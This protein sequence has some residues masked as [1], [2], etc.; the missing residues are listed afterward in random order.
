MWVDFH[1]AL[2]MYYILTDNLT[3]CDIPAV[4]FAP[5]QVLTTPHSLRGAGGGRI[6]LVGGPPPAA[7]LH[8]GQV[9]ACDSTELGC[10]G[11]LTT[12][13]PGGAQM[14]SV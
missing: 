11:T 8:T 12:G 14:C 3:P 9:V 13:W 10:L 5:R 6:L 7:P 1:G 2:I 4:S